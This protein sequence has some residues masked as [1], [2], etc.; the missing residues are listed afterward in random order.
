MP[1]EIAGNKF[2]TP[3]EVAKILGTSAAA[4]RHLMRRGVITAHKFGPRKWYISEA[5]LLESLSGTAKRSENKS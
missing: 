4:V 3:A 1:I 5:V 2:Y